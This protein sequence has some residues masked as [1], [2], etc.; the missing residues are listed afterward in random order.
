MSRARVAI[1]TGSR[2]EFGLLLPVIRAVEAH[3]ALEPRLIV[4]GAHFLPPA[5]TVADI[6]RL[7]LPIDA[8]V[9]MQRAGD[10]TRA[11]D[12]RAVARGIAGFTDAIERIAPSWTLVLGDRVEAFAAAA[13]ASISGRPLAHLHGGDRAEGIADEAMRHA[14]TKLAHLHL[15]ATDQSAQRTARLGEDA[16]RIRT[17]GSPAIDALHAIDPMPDDEWRSL[18]APGAVLLLHP[19]GLSEQAERAVARACVEALAMLGVTPLVLHPNHDPG[20]QWTLDELIRSAEQRGWPVADHLP[21]PRFI[22]LLKR[23]ALDPGAFIIGNSSAA[24]IECAAL[25]LPAVNLGPRQAGRERAGNA[26][27]AAGGTQTSVAHAIERA[28]A[29]DRSALAH[30]YGDGHAGA[31]AAEALASIDPLNGASGA[32]LRKRCVY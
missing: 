3:P 2:A 15:P 4:A 28:L 7:G 21:R 12:A 26:V 10:A 1:V 22:A 17:I 31:R 30:P 32:W 18:G 23:L 14:I 9:E 20:R 25:R 6:E 5:P 16:W 24:L 11:D 27:D 13:A 19:A 29:I 8:R